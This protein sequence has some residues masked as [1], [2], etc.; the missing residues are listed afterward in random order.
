ML[1]FIDS[2]R[3]SRLI[4]LACI[5]I[6]LVALVEA[7]EWPKSSLKISTPTKV[8]WK[9]RGFSSGITMGSRTASLGAT[10]SIAQ[11]KGKIEP[12]KTSGADM[13]NKSPALPANESI[14]VTMTAA[15]KP[16]PASTPK[17]AKNDAPTEEEERQMTREETLNS[18]LHHIDKIYGKGS[19][20]RLG[21]ASSMNIE[22]F[23]SGA[24]TL[25]LALGGGY[26][27][28]RVIEIFGPES[29]GKTTLALHAVASLQKDGGSFVDLCINRMFTILDMVLT[30]LVASPHYIDMQVKPH[31]STQSMR[32]TP[33]TPARSV[34]RHLIYSYASLTTERWR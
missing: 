9:P 33:F 10:A 2:K 13:T 6:I 18:V 7:F 24:L 5:G 32:L 17:K 1:I 20:L 30:A 34:L 27:K 4:L 8:S 26:P 25:D 3:S 15:A 28:G 23:S 21:D 31:T 12:K 14:T 16:S 29:S 22:T 11:N 19:I